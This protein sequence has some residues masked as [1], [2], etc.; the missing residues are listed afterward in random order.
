MRPSIRRLAVA[1]A[2]VAGGLS[3]AGAGGAIAAA[4]PDTAATAAPASRIY[5]QRTA[6][7]RIV[8]TDRPSPAE[9]IER[10]WQIETDDPALARRRAEDMQARARAVS[11]RVQRLIDRQRRAAL[12]DSLQARLARAELERPPAVDLPADPTRIDTGVLWTPYGPGFGYRG[13]ADR[14]RDR[15]RDRGR[16]IEPGPDRPSE[17]GRDTG[18]FRGPA[19]P[20]SR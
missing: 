18:R 13:R 20:E 6:D 17:P 1:V 3:C 14:P 8:L 16:S 2:V 19:A 5:Q 7:G 15:D 4:G 9:T 10:A 12:D 11:E